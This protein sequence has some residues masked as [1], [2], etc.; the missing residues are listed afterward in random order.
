MVAW[1]NK[2][3]RKASVIVTNLHFFSTG[4]RLGSAHCTAAFTSISCSVLSFHSTQSREKQL[5]LLLGSNTTKAIMFYCLPLIRYS[6]ISA[7]P[8]AALTAFMSPS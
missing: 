1:S 7:S 4:M 8:S 3:L 2:P 6:P 5:H